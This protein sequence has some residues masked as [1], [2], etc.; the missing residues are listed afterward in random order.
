MI[1]SIYARSGIYVS[2]QKD[3]YDLV[4]FT[5]FDCNWKSPSYIAADFEIL[6]D[7]CKAHF[8]TCTSKTTAIVM[9]MGISLLTPKRRHLVTTLAKDGSWVQFDSS[10]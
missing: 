7:G 5:C 1:V 6:Q 10:R 8:L 2:K 9:D 3:G 4:R